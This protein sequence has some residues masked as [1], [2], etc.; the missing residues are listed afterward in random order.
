MSAWEAVG[1]SDEWYTPKYIFDSLGCEFDQDVAAPEKRIH[2][3]VP[4]LDFITQASLEKPW[5]GFVWCNPPF[6]KRNEIGLWLDKMYLH[7]DGIALS[8]D[9]TSAPWWQKAAKE[10]DCI[11]F[12]AGKIKF[13]KPDGSV[14]KSPGTGTT[15]FGYGVKAVECLMNA[16]NNGL[17]IL[18]SIP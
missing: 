14:G 12:V 10:A 15:L 2:C 7:G 13:I 5:Q 1:K 8:P 9:R 18:V 6:G 17:G 16:R 11:L 4:A 3:Y